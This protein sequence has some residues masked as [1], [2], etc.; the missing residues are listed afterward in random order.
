MALV[1]TGCIINKMGIL[2]DKTLT[3]CALTLVVAACGSD[4]PVEHEDFGRVCM[5]DAAPNLD[6]IPLSERPK[7]RQSYAEDAS[8]HIVYSLGACLSSTCSTNRTASCQVT[9][10]SNVLLISSRASYTPIHGR[11]CSGDCERPSAECVTAPLAAGTY[12]IRH[13]NSET[14]LTIPSEG[15]PVCLATRR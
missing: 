15:E 9:R 11:P 8:L 14:Q 6:L 13:G 7:E 12:T 2:V 3:F 10:N 5:F 4:E 1:S